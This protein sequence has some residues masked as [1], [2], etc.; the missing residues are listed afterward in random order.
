MTSHPP[1]LPFQL[2][3]LAHKMTI[4]FFIALSQLS[5]LFANSTLPNT[6]SASASDEQRLARLENLTQAN[7]IE[8]ARLLA[9][10]MA[11]FA[12]DEEGQKNLRGKVKEWLVQNTI[13]ADPEVRDALGRAIQRRRVGAPSGAR[14]RGDG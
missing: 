8:A 14:Y 3:V 9:L 1:L 10:E 13:R 11:P 7:E 4:T 6:S 2:L 12:G 5:P